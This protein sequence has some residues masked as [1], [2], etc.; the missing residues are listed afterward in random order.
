MAKPKNN[1]IPPVDPDVQAVIDHAFRGKPLDPKVRRRIERRAEAIRRRIL[2]EH[3]LV[4]IAVPTIRE[5]RGE[6][7][8]P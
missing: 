8:G 5:L 1:G 7:P 2:K 3:G 6:L 4:D